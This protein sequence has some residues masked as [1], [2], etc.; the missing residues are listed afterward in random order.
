MKKRLAVLVLFAALAVFIWFSDVREY[1]TFENL[2]EQS[3]LLQRIVE[4]HYVLSAAVFV[5]FLISTAFFVPGAIVSTVAAGFLFGVIPGTVYVNLGSVIGAI[6]AFLSSRFIFGNWIQKKY[7]KQLKYFNEEMERHGH[8]YLF[9]LRI[10]P[11]LPFFLVNYL[12]GLTR[13]S[14]KKFIVTTS[15]GMLPG[16]LVYTFAGRQLAQLERPEDVFSL[17]LLMAFLFLVV[18]ALSPLIKSLIDRWRS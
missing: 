2:K 17:K 11:I 1:L 3:G 15:I 7:Q 18:F 12:A 8:N 16:S 13:M 9:V 14:L 5:T 10:V 6:L 4:E